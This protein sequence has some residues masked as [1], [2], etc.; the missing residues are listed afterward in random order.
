[1]IFPAQ[2]RAARALLNISQREL[3]ETSG[4]GLA[5]IKRLETRD[6]LAGAARTIGRLQEVLEGQGIDFINQD[7]RDGP[8]VRLTTRLEL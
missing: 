4:V 5:T 2:I 1:M 3:A 7:E 6:G 8:G